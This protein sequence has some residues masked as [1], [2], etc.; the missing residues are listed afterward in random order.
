MT[1]VL[2]FIGFV[3]LTTTGVLMHYSLPPGSGHF[4][5]IWGLN[6]HDWGEIHFWI[7]VGFLGVLSI[8]LFL[9]GRW[10]GHIIRGRKKENFTT[11][12]ALGVVAGAALLALAISPIFSPVE[13]NSG[14]NQHGIIPTTSRA[15]PKSSLIN[16]RMTLAELEQATG[17]PTDYF[18]EQLGLPT[19]VDREERLGHLRRTYG[20]RLNEV[21]QIVESYKK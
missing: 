3:L 7:A 5:T 10:I 1:D 4:R 2:A 15:S 8:H 19:T 9:H 18:I 13:I 14:V 16:G 12:I 21:R 11:R 20:F 6:R 17:V